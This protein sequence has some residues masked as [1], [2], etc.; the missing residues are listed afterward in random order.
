MRLDALCCALVESRVLPHAV[1]K[2]E[3]VARLRAAVPAAAG[4]AAQLE[5]VQHVSGAREIICEQQSAE[6]GLTRRSHAA[7][8]R[9]ELS[10]MGV[11]CTRR[12]GARRGPHMLPP[13]AAVL[14]RFDERSGGGTATRRGRGPPHQRL[15][16]RARP[17]LA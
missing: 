1:Q 6:R 13:P 9:A 2:P 16:R 12:H 8:L 14:A 4:A 17:R 10:G 7:L 5:L 3:R 15:A 11:A